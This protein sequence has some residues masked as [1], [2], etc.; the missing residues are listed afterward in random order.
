VLQYGELRWEVNDPAE[1][2]GGDG[3]HS[4][5][6]RAIHLSGGKDSMKIEVGDNMTGRGDVSRRPAGE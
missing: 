6:A 4:A 5:K 2:V 1:R 3:F